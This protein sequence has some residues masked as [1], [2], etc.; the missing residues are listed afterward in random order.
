MI[1]KVFRQAD[2]EESGSI[3]ASIVPSLAAKALGTV[4]ESEMH[5]IRYRAEAKAGRLT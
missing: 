1:A 5:L 4:K 2:T 3:D